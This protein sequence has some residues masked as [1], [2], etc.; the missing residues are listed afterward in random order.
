M[1]TNK[2]NKNKKRF[3]QQSANL[4]IVKTAKSYHIW[5]NKGSNEAKFILKNLKIWW[6]S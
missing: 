2:K 3:S 6:E 5:H 4:S 1:L